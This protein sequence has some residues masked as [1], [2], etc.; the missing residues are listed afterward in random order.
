MTNQKESVT[1]S[2]AQTKS[3]KKDPLGEYSSIVWTLALIFFVRGFIVEPFQI[4]SG[5]MIPTLLVGDR[6][7]VAKSSYDIGIPFTN[8]KLFK[9]SDPQ[10]GDV[11][12]FEYPN[13]ENDQQRRGYFYIK[14]ILG[15]PGD[16]IQVQN[17]TPSVNG[18]KVTQ[19][20]ITDD[21]SKILMPAFDVGPSNFLFRETIPGG[22]QSGHWVQRYG[23]TLQD[24]PL[25]KGELLARG[26]P[27]CL[28]VGTAFKMSDNLRRFV[29][30]NEVCKFKV[31]ENYYFVMGDNRDD[32]ADG[33]EWGFVERKL[34]KGRALFI[35]A[36]V[37]SKN[38]SLDAMTW[39]DVLMSPL[40]FSE[41]WSDWK[42][43]YS[44]FG[45]SIL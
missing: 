36:S 25:A 44:R 31:P 18:E 4:P 42:F 20:E 33:R 22:R 2:S 28:E 41:W 29:A 1:T 39:I 24:I 3:Q 26:G 10:R 15:I 6:L 11:A 40:K 9:V 45:L 17:G 30:M 21:E 38:E 14:R 34:L 8:L 43:R 7:F 12:V 32:S 19:V 35:W 27:E 23:N 37:K 16:E 13:F 5:S